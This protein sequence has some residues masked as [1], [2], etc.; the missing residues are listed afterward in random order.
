M[1]GFDRSSA[2]RFTRA[3][4][5]WITGGRQLR[6]CVGFRQMMPTIN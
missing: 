5:S 4:Q 6:V 1:P 3:V 2:I